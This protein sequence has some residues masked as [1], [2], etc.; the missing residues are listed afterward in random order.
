MRTANRAV[1]LQSE[2][3]HFDTSQKDLYEKKNRKYRRL[4]PIHENE[5]SWKTRMHTNKLLYTQMKS[6]IKLF[7][8]LILLGGAPA[9]ACKGNGIPYSAEKIPRES[10]EARND[11]DTFLIKLP[12]IYKGSK[13]SSIFYFNGSASIPIQFSEQDEN[14]EVSAYF[15]SK[16]AHMKEIEFEASYHPLPAKD[17]SLALCVKTQVIKFGI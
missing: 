13:L 1:I 17:G 14:N 10:F 4:Q 6:S 15:H 2:H 11:F 3:A 7:A 16:I 8:C 12:Y 5:S 9:F